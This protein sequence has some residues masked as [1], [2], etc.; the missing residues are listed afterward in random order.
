M[1]DVRRVVLTMS[2]E[3]VVWV[4]INWPFG[5]L[6]CKSHLLHNFCFNTPNL[7]ILIQVRHNYS[8]NWTLGSW[9]WGIILVLSLC[10]HEHCCYAFSLLL[11]FCLFWLSFLMSLIAIF[12]VIIW[13]KIVVI[14]K[15]YM[16][17]T[18]NNTA[19]ELMILCCNEPHLFW[20][21]V[22]PLRL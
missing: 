10:F 4:N 6:C 22:P 18:A 5:D 15:L 7:S 21:I 9:R 3:D 14:K 2:L 13:N 11:W 20:T 19:F 1:S 8:K 16:F 17:A 12:T